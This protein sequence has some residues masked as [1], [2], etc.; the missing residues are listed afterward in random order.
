MRLHLLEWRTKK[1]KPQ[2]SSVK[3]LPLLCKN[4][5]YLLKKKK[6]TRKETGISVGLKGMFMNRRSPNL[7]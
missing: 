4:R 7:S 3:K 1:I 6:R 2:T 5:F